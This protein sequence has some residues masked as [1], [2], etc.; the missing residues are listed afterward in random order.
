[1]EDQPELILNVDDTDATRYAKT[2]TL[3]R[4]GYCVIEA[5]T[6]SEALRLAQSKLPALIILDT[7]LPDVNGFELCRLI[8]QTPETSKILVLQTS[9]SYVT[10]PDKIHGIECGA[11]NYLF[12]PIEPEELVANVQALLRLGRVERELREVDQRKDEFLAVLAHELRN[13]LGPIRNAAEVLR[14]L[15]PSA[16]GPQAAA[17]G[18]ILRQVKQMTR[19]VDDLLDVSRISRGKIDL[20]RTAVRVSDIMQAAIETSM[21]QILARQHELVAGPMDTEIW[22]NGDLA[23]LSQSVANLLNNAAK[24]TA[25]QG[26]ISIS[27]WQEP[28]LAV[29]RVRDNGIG[30]ERHQASRIF[31]MFAQAGHTSDRVQDGLGIGL[32]LVRTLTELHGGKISVASDGPG[33]GSTF[34]IRLPAIQAPVVLD[35]SA[36]AGADRPP[37]YSILIIDDNADAAE[38]LSAL[39]TTNGHHV[40]VVHTGTDGIAAAKEQKPD[41]VIVDI[42]LPDMNGMQVA[43]R[44]RADDS[45]SGAVLIALTGY[46]QAS[47]RARAEGSGFNNYLTKP[48]GLS[49]LMASFDTRTLH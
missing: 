39:L 23:R 27:S 14:M 6:G 19:L 25:P 26:K 40:S 29:I 2:R 24:F 44:L 7:K 46:G 33:K 22:V 36:G 35:A 21:P 8:K 37:S 3:L 43:Q 41:I 10:T 5:A 49:A 12:E 47:D 30:I 28:G 4:Q 48:V 13:P 9:A 31:D 42:G 34:E 38:M 16:P 32:S 45:L 18:V 17:L 15:N 20:R 11:D 1:M